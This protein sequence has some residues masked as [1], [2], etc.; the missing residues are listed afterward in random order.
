MRS[1]CLLVVIALSLWASASSAQSADASR[2]TEARAHYDRGVALFDEEQFVAALAEFEAA[3]ALTARPALLFN[4]GQIHA[5]LGHAVEAT[6]VL[7]RYLAE[8]PEI[9]PERRS[10]VE[11]EIATQRS[12]I[13][14]VRV[15]VRTRGELLSGAAVSL[16]DVARGTTPLEAPLRVSAGEH[17]LS[18]VAAGH[19]ATRERFRV[20][21]GEERTLLLELVRNAPDATV[22]TSSSTAPT[23]RPERAFPALTVVGASLAGAG[24]VTFVVSGVVTLLEAARLGR[25]LA[26]GGCSPSCTTAETATI[27]VTRIV[28]D[29][30]LG[31]LALG[32]VLTVIGAVLELGGES[33]TEGPQL[34]L[35][36]SGLEVQW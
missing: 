1:F 19:E 31:A 18:V 13:G 5:R 32:G 2:E 17:V 30:G 27:D 33:E 34:S 24:L 3:Y 15:E 23:T 20:A 12:R 36:A 8:M 9:A 35:H 14:L 11:S 25:P 10:L 4:I 22:S 6:D 21:G 7:G 29:V 16:D 28:A 26:E